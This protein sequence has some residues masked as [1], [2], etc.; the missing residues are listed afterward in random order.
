M[1]FDYAALVM[2]MILATLVVIILIKLIY[3]HNPHYSELFMGEKLSFF[4]VQR[5]IKEECG[6]LI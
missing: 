1:Q 4:T 6:D 2:V 3:R 5:D